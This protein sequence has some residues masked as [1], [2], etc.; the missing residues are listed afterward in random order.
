VLST[1]VE[2]EFPR[3]GVKEEGKGT[4][5]RNKEKEQGGPGPLVEP[6]GLPPEKARR[7]GPRN[8]RYSMRHLRYISKSDRLLVE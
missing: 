3:E 1:G 5:G 4:R 6:P 7:E 2:D 8:A